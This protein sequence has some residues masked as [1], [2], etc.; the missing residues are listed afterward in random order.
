MEKCT[1]SKGGERWETSTPHILF[2]FVDDECVAAVGLLL[3]L[4]VSRVISMRI[5]D[6]SN[7]DV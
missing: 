2:S 4:G 7:L 5:C 3:L 1:I 6:N